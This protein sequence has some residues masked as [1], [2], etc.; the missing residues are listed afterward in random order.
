[1]HQR[2]HSKS[3]LEPDLMQ[4]DIMTANSFTKSTDSLKD[5]KETDGFSM[6][7]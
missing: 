4:Q 6:A 2:G 1:M 5:K 7:T 3:S